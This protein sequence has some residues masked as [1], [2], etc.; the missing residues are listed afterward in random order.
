MRFTGRFQFSSDRYIFIY[1]YIREINRRKKK[2]INCLY[3]HHDF[4][5]HWHY[6]ATWK[7]NLVVFKLLRLLFFTFYGSGAI[8]GARKTIAGWRSASKDWQKTH[9]WWLRHTRDDMLIRHHTTTKNHK[10]LHRWTS[11]GSSLQL[12][13]VCM[14][15]IWFLCKC[16]HHIYMTK[17]PFS[18]MWYYQLQQHMKLVLDILR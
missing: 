12:A 7:S 10:L 6:I 18:C 9:E 8:I 17:D 13:S 11:C 16:W 5:Y 1:I 3:V 14:H 15:Q 2:L 4:H